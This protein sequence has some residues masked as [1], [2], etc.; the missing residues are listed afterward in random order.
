VKIVRVPLVVAVIMTTVGLLPATAGGFTTKRVSVSSGGVEAN[1]SMYNADIS[2]DGRFVVFSTNATNLVANDL[3]ANTDVF[4]HDRETGRTRLVSVSPHE[5]QG[6]G[7]S[8]EYAVAISGNGRFVAFESSATNLVPG[9]TNAHEDIFVRDLHNGT[10][11]RVSIRSNGGQADEASYERVDL[12]RD[13]RLV[14]FNSLATNLVPGDTNAVSDVFVHDRASG[15]TQRVSVRSN[16]NEGDDESGRSAVAISADGHVVAFDSTATNLVPQDTNGYQDIF[17]HDRSTGRT[18]RVS[19]RSNGLQG[20]GDTYAHVAIS[21]TGRFVAFPSDA[22]N[23]V[24]GDTNAVR[25]VFLHDMGT[26]RTRRVSVAASGEQGDGASGFGGTGQPPA[27]SLSGGGRYVLFASVATNLVGSDTNAV[28]DI[29]VHDLE[30]GSTRRVSRRS[31]GNQSNGAS[32]VHGASLTATGRFA[33]YTSDATN[34]V[35]GDTN[36]YTDV[37]VSG[38]LT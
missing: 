4:V 5:H 29:F 19:V 15:R 24:Q 32:E 2:A 34:L 7:I 30:R 28:A 14:A 17:V 3:N 6:N 31:N 36:G 26:G 11:E 37:F 10:T 35:S 12:S 27:V 18:H 8:G 23:L 25:D 22:T 16:G 20:N 21:A 38:P 1:D 13:G 33:A 9:D